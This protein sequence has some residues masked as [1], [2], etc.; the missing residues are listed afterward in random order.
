MRALCLVILLMLCVVSASATPH[1]FWGGKSLFLLGVTIF[2]SLLTLIIVIFRK[3]GLQP[4]F[5]RVV[6][7]LLCLAFVGL[8]CF[9]GWS[10]Y[11][12]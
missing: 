9:L 3:E 1:P 6:S 5:G 11:T 2:F 10:W 8:C 4:L 12:L 7:T